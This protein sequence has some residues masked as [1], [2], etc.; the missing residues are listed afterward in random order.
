MSLIDKLAREILAKLPEDLLAE[1]ADTQKVL[2]EI[3]RLAEEKGKDLTVHAL[4]QIFPEDFKNLRN[5][6]IKLIGSEADSLLFKKHY[7]RARITR[8]SEFL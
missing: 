2:D 1:D 4:A 6:A 5:E 8:A 7:P 3:Y